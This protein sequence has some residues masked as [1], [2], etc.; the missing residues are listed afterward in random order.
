[1]G[2]IDEIL[3]QAKQR[4]TELNLP[5]AGALFPDEAYELL[6]EDE[7]ARLIDVRTRA[8]QD[9]VG[10]IPGAIEVELMT[11][12]GMKPN[13]E[14]L[15]Q[16][17][18]QIEKDTLALF[19]CRSGA[20]SNAAATNAAKAGFSQCYNVLEGFEGDKDADEHRNTLGGWKAAELPWE[21]S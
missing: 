17:N 16:L 21:Q 4:A 11:Y 5:Y 6:Q 10:R 1:M 14:F 13:S 8:E 7:Q 15:N 20:R 9:W 3:A 2:K 12:P 19:L 18:T